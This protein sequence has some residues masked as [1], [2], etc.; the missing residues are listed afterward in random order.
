MRIESPPIPEMSDLLVHDLLIPGH[1]EWDIELLHELFD[2]RDI[3]QIISTPLVG[4]NQED[5]RIWHFSEN[6][7]YTVKS[8]YKIAMD[9]SINADVQEHEGWKK[10]WA[11]KLPP[12]VKIFLWRLGRNCL[13]VRDNLQKK[14]ISVPL[15]CGLC[16]N[17]MENNWHLFISCRFAQDCWHESK[18]YDMIESSSLNA[19][20]FTELFFML[21]SKLKGF[22][23]TKFGMIL[24]NIWRQ[25]NDKVW[26]DTHKDPS[27]SVRLAMEFLC[28]WLR[29]K[30]ISQEIASAD[31]LDSGYSDWYRPPRSFVKCNVDAAFFISE[32]KIGIG[33]ILR[34]E[35]GMFLRCRTCIIVGMVSVKEGEAMGL[36]EALSWVQSLGLKKVCF[37]MDAK[38]VVD[39]IKSSGADVS[40]FGSIVQH[41]KD[42]IRYEHEFSISFIRR[43][44]NECAHAL[45]KVSRSY[46]S[47]MVW[48]EP[49]DCITSF[50]SYSCNNP[51]HH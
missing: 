10:L 46:A 19:E 48:S 23:Q 30:Q 32:Q 29:A 16:N 9:L 31:S 12:K 26:T 42:L 3:T 6:G 15:V 34:D 8:G 1:K 37:E 28:D 45:A 50:L 2:E 7:F 5:V 25:R 39:A 24:W 43:Q 18:L 11:L 35:N 38:V 4:R 27:T 17:G 49:P 40:E 33:C 21:L 51:D 41:C 14:R 44:A 47:P 13:P 20:S 36:R 22:E